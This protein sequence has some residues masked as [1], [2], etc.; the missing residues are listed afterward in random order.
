MMLLLMLALVFGSIFIAFNLFISNYARSNVENQLDQLVKDFGAKAE[1]H[2]FYSSES[3]DRQR[4]KTSTRGEVIVLDFNYEI[5]NYNPL[6]VNEDLEELIQIASYLKNHHIPLADARYE[7]VNT[8]EGDYYISSIE[9]EKQPGSFFVFYFSMAGIDHLVHTI[10][11]AMAVI[12]GIAMVICFLIS[13]TIAGSITK[14][15]RELFAFAE[16]IGRG[17]F[18]RKQFSF[19][20]IEFEELGEAMNQAAEKLDLYD[21]DQRA[22][23]Q[24][25]SH[26]LRTPLQSI[27]CYAEGVEYGLMEPKKSGATIIAETDRLSELVEDLLYISRMDSLTTH[28]EMTEN[29]L[30][31]TLALCAESLRPVADKAGLQIQYLFDEKP[32]LF[33]Y[34]EKH[35]YRSFSNLLSNAIRYAVH[36]ITLRCRESN[37]QIEISVI[38][39]GPGISAEDL[40]HIF[41]RFYKGRDGKHG[42][43]LSIV[44]SVVQ[45]HGGEITVACT[46]DEGTR[47][48]ILFQKKSDRTA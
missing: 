20:D 5:Q 14:P 40:P 22:F 19:R 33:S 28:V 16:Q 31:D 3:N 8:E 24:N 41:E 7:F 30:R 34:N 13:N 11:F 6:S 15:F 38:D 21:K 45:L 46:E 25:V 48:T 32:V 35:M 43:G 2:E 17:N 47:F 36:T 18:K 1:K 37:E 9:N 23:F 10:N 39:D 27:R 12:V 29:D 44:K 42:I 4:N 26:E